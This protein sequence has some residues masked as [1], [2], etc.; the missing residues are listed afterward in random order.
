MVML[1]LIILAS[2]DVVQGSA[3]LVCLNNYEMIMLML[4]LIILGSFD[5]VQGS[6]WLV[7]ATD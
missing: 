6:A 3:W 4:M 5:V 1:M 2:F 7:L